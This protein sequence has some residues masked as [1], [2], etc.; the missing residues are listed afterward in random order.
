MKNG[1]LDSISLIVI[2]LN[3]L[4][5]WIDADYVSKVNSD[6]ANFIPSIDVAFLLFYMIELMIVTFAHERI[7]DVINDGWHVFNSFLVVVMGL[8]LSVSLTFA[9]V[10]SSNNGNGWQALDN[11][12]VL[13]LIRITRLLQIL[14]FM[15]VVPEILFLIK[16]AVAATRSVVITMLMLLSITYAAGITCR[17]ISEGT[18]MGQKYFPTVMEAMYNLIMRGVLLDSVSSMMT[19]VAEGSTICALIFALV[20]VLGAI[21]MM[22]MLVGVLVDVM[23]TVAGQEKTK[24]ASSMLTEKVRQIIAE[25]GI[26]SGDANVITLQ[27]FRLLLTTRATANALREIDVEPEALVDLADGIFQ[28]DSEGK[29]FDKEIGFEEF[30]DLLMQLRGSNTVTVRDLQELKCFILAQNTKR[31]LSL[32]RL[33]ERMNSAEVLSERIE[34]TMRLLL[35]NQV[36]GAP[37]DASSR[38]GSP[39]MRNGA[40]QMLRLAL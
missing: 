31:N 2:V 17:Q 15:H 38:S 10:G 12:K 26:E 1:V 19:D 22:N 8:E 20:I 24:L 14:R 21:T 13:R 34:A 25:S 35:R 4:W 33:E 29:F 37:Q 18:P 32:R 9:I 36:H 40:Q 39:Q 28:S 6:V 27:K 16:G 23:N 5:L 7:R 3:S 11:L 30:M